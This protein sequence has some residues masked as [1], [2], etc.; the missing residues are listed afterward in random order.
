[1]PSDRPWKLSVGLYVACVSALA[2]LAFFY[3]FLFDPALHRA[4]NPTGLLAFTA[5]GLGLQH[6]EHKLAVSSVTGAIS[7]IVYIAA[8]LVFGPTWGAA[9]TGV[10]IGA[11][12]AVR[13]NP[14]IKIVFNV[15]QHILAIIAGSFVYISLGGE[16]PPQSLDGVILPFFGFVLGFFT[17]NTVAVSG[18]VAVSDRRPFAEV[19]I[20]NT[21]SFALYDLA[22]SAV[23][24]AI[25]WLY[26]HTPLGVFG[27]AVVVLP[28]LFIRHVYLINQQLQDTNR[29]LLELMVKAI[30]ARDPYTSGHSQRVSD[31]AR[32][33][34]RE[35]GLGFREVE[36]IATAA[37][38]H[39][40]GKIHEEYAPLLRKE[41]KL[42]EEEKRL[43]DSH[44][45]RSAELVGTISNLRGPVERYVRHHH[46]DY[47]GSGYPD[48]LSG[49]EI[50]VGARII[51]IAD[52]ADAMTTD[53][54]YRN[55]LTYDRVL[56]VLAR[57]SWKQFDPRLV[58]AFRTSAEIRR[59][60]ESRLQSER[61]S[62][63][64]V[65]ASGEQVIPLPSPHSSVSEPVA[66]K[67]P[68]RPAAIT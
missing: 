18:V 50:P 19:W 35:I 24:L 8:V 45:V 60:I 10:S 21:W 39:D 23:S 28:I 1:M 41:G 26:A 30:E 65:A 12:Q 49:E 6:A 9:I 66:W 61:R 14:A 16:F 5:L 68:S 38:L 17:V 31:V 15:A 44:A 63:H 47:D 22:A 36:S 25:V 29:E 33:L 51:A 32:V 3:S 4:I 2:T 53:R 52:T 58:S 20:K 27:I 54:P 43:M 13:R 37:L 57:F 48:G 11:V 34:A 67:G 40:V 59:M 46:E 64:V 56:S 42:T 7:F 55:A 62:G